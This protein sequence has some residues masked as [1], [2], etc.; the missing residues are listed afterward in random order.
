MSGVQSGSSLAQVWLRSGSSLAPVW[1]QSGSS[2][3]QVWLRSGSG[4]APVWLQSGSLCLGVPVSPPSD[5]RSLTVRP[6]V[7]D[8]LAVGRR[9]KPLS[10]RGGGRSPW[11]F[12]GV[13]FSESDTSHRGMK[14]LGRALERGLER[15]LERA[16]ES[17]GYHL[18]A[19]DRIGDHWR[20][21]WR[22]LGRALERGRTPWGG[23]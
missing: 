2:L 8:R 10:L 11:V 3:A 18:R 22:T 23:R 13:G 16:L 1:L 21:H 6:S 5:R 17:I 15:A 4:R 20:D 14:R 12:P 9:P 19:L 7:S